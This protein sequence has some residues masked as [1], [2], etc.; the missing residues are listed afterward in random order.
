[1]S[2]ML[3]RALSGAVYIAVIVASLMFGD[4]ALFAPL[5]LILTAWGTIEFIKLFKLHTNLTASIAG[6]LF[7]IATYAIFAL[8]PW[9]PDDTPTLACILIPLSAIVLISALY[10]K[11]ENAFQ[12][13]VLTLFPALYIA[14]PFALLINL[15]SLYDSTTILGFFI[16][17]WA[18]DTFAYLCGR[19]FGKHPFFKRI[20]PKKTWEGFIGSC[21]CTTILGLAIGIYLDQIAQWIG[22][23]IIIVIF[24]ALGDLIESLYKRSLNVKDSGKFLPGH[25]G[26]LD[27]FDSVFLAAPM[28][29]AYLKLLEWLN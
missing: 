19:L 27:R 3:I 13:A 15:H 18:S 16:L 12:A 28:V 23:A 24:G 29:Y 21:I 7:S 26:L 4:G 17:L 9:L 8:A 1:M 25:G 10:S 20:S 6:T 14:I 2:N 5:L 11:Q 22:M